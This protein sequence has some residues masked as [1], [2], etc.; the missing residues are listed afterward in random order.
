[1]QNNL[2]SVERLQHYA[3]DIEQEAPSE[4]PSTQPPA[5]W[6]SQGAIEFKDVVLNYRPGLPNVL[7]GL[8]IKGMLSRGFS[9]IFSARILLDNHLQ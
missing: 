5:D 4:I 3:V 7:H 6:P 2:G 8:S 9:A 1:M